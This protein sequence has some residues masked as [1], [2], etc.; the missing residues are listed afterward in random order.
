M[1]SNAKWIKTG[2]DIGT[3]SPEFVKHVSVRKGVVRATA[4]VSAI[5]VYNFYVD[6]VKVGDGVLTP[7]FTSYQYRVLYQT[8]DI[9]DMLREG[10]NRLSILCGKGWAMSFLG[11]GQDREKNF[12]D[13][14]SAIADVEIEYADGSLESIVTDT[15]WDAYTSCVLDSDIYNG[16]TVDM[17]SDIRYCGK[18]VE[19]TAS[20]P[21]LESQE[22]EFVKEQDRVSV[23]EVIKTPKGETVLDFGQNIAGYVEIRIK[24]KRGDRI[25]LSHAEVLDSEGNFY[26]ENMRKAKNL[27]TYVLS[28]GED[29]FKPRFCWQG[30]RYIRL[31]ECPEGVSPD[32]FCA[33]AI[34]TDMKRTGR[35]VCG[36]DDINQLYSNII[37]G[38]KGNYIDIP[39]DCPQRNE[40]QG[41]AADAQVFCRTGAIN[42]DV[43]AFFD[44]WLR[45]MMLEQEEDGKVYRLC[46]YYKKDRGGRISTGWSDAATVV[47]WEIYRA[48][49]HKE[50]LEKYYPMMTKWVDWIRSFGDE[51]FLWIGG[52]HYGDWLAMDAGDD[53]YYGATQTDLI[54]SAYFAY[55]TALVIKAGRVLDKDVSEYEELL[56]NIKKEFRRAFMK[57]GRPVI[58]PKA[59]A[60]ATN[61]P[62]KADTQTACAMILCFDLCEPSERAGLAAHL[63]EMIK[64]NDGLMTTGFLGTPILLHVLAKNGYSDVAYSLLFEERCPSWL[65]SVK[66][67]ATTMWE[68]WNNIKE[69]G[70]FWSSDMNSFNHYAYGAVFDW[71]FE[72][73]GGISVCDGG[74][75]YTHVR[76]SPI[77]DRRLGFA[78]V[79]IETIRG[80]LS[81]KWRYDGDTVI[82]DICV[83]DGTRADICIDEVTRSVTGGSYKFYGRV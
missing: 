51:E 78:D 34:H 22:S 26:T 23:R 69:D 10:E 47:P 18:V 42:F 12:A 3:V 27:C 66:H 54:A 15:E 80:E 72:Y 48:Y 76:I 60:F 45:D 28:G 81:V 70:S 35:F 75:G 43:E 56:K 65:Y 16:E 44:K 24:G 2:E 50:I 7:G 37:W 79:G 40:R 32:S 61:R 38:Q 14:V 9:T 1:N 8:Y 57:D 30:F 20:K 77:P 52:D 19:D 36:N 55:S 6:G 41:W 58:Y 74:E 49:G 71:I 21:M 67:G 59:D 64:E 31:D 62:V 53:S 17:T 5:G 82:Y 11:T 83:P 13:N 63:A 33:I 68:H 25:V 46:P 4:K 39:T 29:V 73:V